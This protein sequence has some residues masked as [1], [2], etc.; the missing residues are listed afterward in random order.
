VRENGGKNLNFHFLKVKMAEKRIE[1][2]DDEN[3]R[4]L[5]SR[6]AENSEKMTKN[7]LKTFSDGFWVV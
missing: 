7:V 3:T 1:S 6:H 4:I 5:E 2:E